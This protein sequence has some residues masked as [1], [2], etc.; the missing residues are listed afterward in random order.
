MHSC[1]DSLF[2]NVL[3][4]DHLLESDDALPT[5]L[6]ER[7][8]K[9]ALARSVALEF[10][11]RCV[12]RYDSAGPRSSLSVQSATD[13]MTLCTDKLGDS[14][15]SVRKAAMN[16]FQR[17]QALHDQ[18]ITG[19]VRKAIDGLKTSNSRAYKTLTQNEPA[20]NNCAGPTSEIVAVKT[21]ASNR[22]HSA[23]PAEKTASR[24]AEPSRSFKQSATS[25]KQHAAPNDVSV[26]LFEDALVHMSS[27][28]IPQWDAL[29]DDGG[30]L[31]GL[32]GIQ[33]S[34]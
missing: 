25:E 28:C 18:N 27:L 3:G 2:G 23:A 13:V 16:V 19:V 21:N 34:A 20:V 32:K 22:I 14:D 5:S 30:I 29:D 33:F 26:P 31:E 6:D 17:M 8:N 15:A 4:F 1:L 7:Q 12:E 11:G 10:L 24:V 9:N